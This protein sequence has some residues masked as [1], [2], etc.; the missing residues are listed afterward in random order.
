LRDKDRGK[1][2]KEIGAIEIKLRGF[3]SYITVQKNCGSNID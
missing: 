2:K 1:R 3:Y